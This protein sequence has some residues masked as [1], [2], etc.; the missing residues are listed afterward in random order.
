MKPSFLEEQEIYTAEETA[1]LL[2]IGKQT[3]YNRLSKGKGLPDHFRIGTRVR[4]R[5]ADIIKFI[6]KQIEQ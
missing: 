4:F 1:K 6:E 3:I 2:N 5:G